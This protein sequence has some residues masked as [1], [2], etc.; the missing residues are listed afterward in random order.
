MCVCVCV[1][2]CVCVYRYHRE[3]DILETIDTHQRNG[4]RAGMEIMHLFVA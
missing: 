4:L 1:C 3:S 2:A